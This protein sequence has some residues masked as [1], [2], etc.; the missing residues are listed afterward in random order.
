MQIKAVLDAAAYLSKRKINAKPQIMI[1]QVSSFEELQSVKDIFNELKA[2][3]EKRQK[4][5]L[6]INFGTMLE[7]VRA[8]LISGDLVNIAE[9]SVLEQ[10]I[11]LKLYL[12]LAE[13]M[14]KVNLFLNI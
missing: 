9:F 11:L 5:K 4:I 6:T 10:M 7:V 14:L 1:P 3:I 12:A 2:D 8:C 13:K